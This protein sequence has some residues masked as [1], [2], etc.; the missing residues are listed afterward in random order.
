[1]VPGERPLGSM[2][3]RAKRRGPPPGGRPSRACQ[4]MSR[5]A[6][7][8]GRQARRV[9]VLVG[10]VRQGLGGEL[11]ARR[12]VAGLR[13]AVV[14]CQG[15]GIGARLLVYV[16]AVEGAAVGSGLELGQT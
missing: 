13:V 15:A 4:R 2:T 11:A 7:D 1:M 9:G 16:G 3:V 5:S 12:V 10:D 14:E 6:A 8:A